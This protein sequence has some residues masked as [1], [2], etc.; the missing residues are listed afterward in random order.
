MGGGGGG[1]GNN[2]PFLCRPP[3]PTPL[4]STPGD[5]WLPAKENHPPPPPNPLPTGYLASCSTTYRPIGPF[6][7]LQAT[8]IERRSGLQ[9]K[10]EF[11][12]RFLIE[13]GTLVFVCCVLHHTI[14]PS[15]VLPRF[16][17]S[18]VDALTTLIIS[19]L[20]PP[21]PPPFRPGVTNLLPPLI[22]FL[23][24]RCSP[25]PSLCACVSVCGGG[26]LKLVPNVR[27]LQTARYKA[28]HYPPPPKKKKK[29][30]KKKKNKQTN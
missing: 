2:N 18:H 3:T 19:Y 6:R 11:R 7:T 13:K 10:I 5:E 20:S 24:Q 28:R 29:K 16:S 8:R 26:G 15:T 17:S 4:S 1:G 27:S 12:I 30:T 22:P 25:S 14:P 21:P 9:R 23:H